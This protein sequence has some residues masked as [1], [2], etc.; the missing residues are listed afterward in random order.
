MAEPFD[1]YSL[2]PEAGPD[3]NPYRYNF[4]GRSYY[5]LGSGMG[6]KYW[7]PGYGWVF[8]RNIQGAAGGV[9]PMYPFGTVDSD[10]VKA[11]PIH[12]WDFIRGETGPAGIPSDS[13]IASHHLDC[14]RWLRV[15]AHIDTLNS[16]VEIPLLDANNLPWLS[17][18][19]PWNMIA[20]WCDNSTS[21]NV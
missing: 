7:E 15:A 2:P 20:R 17:P 10:P 3:D 11:K 16:Y 5:W 21:D 6:W 4:G 8:V 14:R 9:A 1:P 18:E 13:S 12:V 19:R